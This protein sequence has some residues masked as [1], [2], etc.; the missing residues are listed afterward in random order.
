[1]L[2]HIHWKWRNAEARRGATEAWRDHSHL[3]TSSSPSGEVGAPDLV[4]RSAGVTNLANLE[5]EK[6]KEEAEEEEQKEEGEQEEERKNKR[7][8]R[9]TQ[10]KEEE[11]ISPG[12]C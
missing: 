3:Q 9:R 2:E 4:G 7:K 1:M 10:E 8:P 11:N 12:R 6:Q 5:E